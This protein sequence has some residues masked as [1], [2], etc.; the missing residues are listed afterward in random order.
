MDS[1]EKTRRVDEQTAIRHKLLEN[2]YVPLPNIDKRCFLKRWSDVEVD[3]DV[4][5]DWADRRSYV[6]TGVRMEGALIALDFDIDDDAM[7]DRVWDAI[8]AHD[9]RLADLMDQMPTRRGKG[10]KL[11]LFC[12]LDTGKIDKLW[13]KAFY[14][15]AEIEAAGDAG[16]AGL[17][18]LEVFSGQTRGRQ[19]GV[20]GAHT[21]ADHEVVREYSWE[22][23]RGLADVALVD[24][25]ALR[26]KDVFDI[27]DIVSRELARAEWVYEVSSRSGK[28]TEIRSY[29]LS[30][31]MQFVTNDGDVLDMEAL[32]ALAGGSMSAGGAGLRVSLSFTEGPSALNTTR[33]LVSLNPGDGR[34]QVWDSAT[35][36]LYRPADLDMKML[37]VDLGARLRARG[38]V[39]GAGG[40]GGGGGGMVPMDRN[41]GLR[42]NESENHA[43]GVAGEAGEA[44]DVVQVLADGAG[45]RVVPVN[46]GEMTSASWAVAEWLAL[47]PD[48]YRMNGLVTSVFDDGAIVS[49]VEARLSV[50]IGGL[51]C[52]TQEHKKGREVE[53]VE[54]DP[55]AMLTRQVAA[56]VGEAPFRD[57]RGVV[58]VPVLRE[59]GGLV[60]ENGWDAGTGLLV[61]AGKVFSGLI[62]DRPTRA[63]AL[64]ALDVLMHPF[65]EFKL[66][67]AESRG[68]LLAALLTAVVRPSLR[69]APAFA[70]DAPS[71]GS[72]KTRL[73]EC[74]M[75][76]GGAG[77]THAPLNMR[78]EEE[79][80]K[81]LLS[82]LLQKPGA[83][84]FDNQVGMVDSASLAA[85]LT[86][87]S[88]SARRLGGSDT[89]VAD[90]NMLMLF[91]GNNMA[92]VGDMTRR[93]LLIRIDPE[94]EVPAA[95][96]FDFDPLAEVKTNR[97]NMVAAALTLIRWA[98]PQ[99][100]LGRVGSFESWDVAVAQTVAA[101]GLDEYADPAA[102]LWATR[103]DDPRME[104]TAMLMV[105]L[106]DLF[107][108]DWF[109][110]AD[111]TDAVSARA[112]GSE[113][114]AA[115]FEHAMNKVTTLGVNRFLRFR[116]DSRVHGL[117]LLM[118][119]PRNKKACSSFRVASNEDSAVVEIG[120][121]REKR[122]RALVK[123][124]H[125]KNPRE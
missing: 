57:L 104:E 92:I 32:E 64:S 43:Q 93:V 5:T 81:V 74:L 112:A 23:G 37:A 36:T 18:R 114:V 109:T 10:A 46:V 60:V 77:R 105:G 55:P 4:I 30:P 111:V 122:Q 3:H 66:D 16:G 6:A 7:L 14:S 8:A 72:G 26:R 75:A 95:R 19:V 15:P 52:C 44:D 97:V 71:A 107:G 63:D 13:S 21:V 116:K 120:S 9:E 42:E 124:D 2:G 99:R 108:S 39:A 118:Q 100:R 119:L 87:P 73:G 82:L 22:D 35:D 41:G 31:D 54:V 56:L 69:T 68:A 90:T 67:G 78:A 96:Q 62:A 88:Y 34:V 61:R 28:I 76:L 106:R 58:D 123:I 125:L 121:W 79:I 45:R 50:E 70:L 47:S 29:T 33:G 103:D 65:R 98:V 102:V 27:V 11:C 1:Q 38:L 101:L 25:P 117:R 94:C 59:D 89:V 86:M 12:R 51:V 85:V 17:H 84:L 24:L 113:P 53:I 115:I 49:M 40:G 20:Y 80:G 48:L 83:V 110:A 91:S